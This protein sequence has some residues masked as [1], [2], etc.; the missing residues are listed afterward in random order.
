[1]SEEEPPF[2]RP[3][4]R[5]RTVSWRFSAVLVI[6]VLALLGTV[7]YE[8]LL[9]HH[10]LSGTAVDAY[11]L[12]PLAGVTVVASG[13]QVV[14]DSHGHFSIS[15]EHDS[16]QA[17][18]QGYE[19]IKATVTSSSGDVRL[20]L[21]PNVVHG[22]VVNG[23]DQNPVAGVQVTLSSGSTAIAHTTT[24]K[25]GT[26]TLTDV[27]EG[28]S[29]QFTAEDFADLSR[30]LDHDT[31]VDVALQPD[32]LRGTLTDDQGKPIAGAVVATG[33]LF[34]T[35]AD[36][37]TYRLKGVSTSGPVVFKASG[38]AATSKSLTPALKLDAS[39]VPIQVK[40]IYA[41]AN[42]ASNQLS[43]DALIKIADTTEVNAIVVDLKDS[44]GH[45]YYDSSVP[46]A[47]QI[48]AIEPE[49]DPALLVELL[50]QHN[51]YAIARIVVFEDPILAEARPDWAIHDSATGGLWRTWNGLA[52]VNAHRSEVW[53]YDVSIAKEAAA[54]GF[55]EIQL[56]YIRF[57]TDGPLNTAE[58]G[59]P[60]NEQTRP[61]AINDFLTQMYAAIAP[62]HAYL[63]A[64]VFGLTM[65]ETGDGNIG[66]NLESVAQ[67]LDY[68]CPMVYPSH[69]ADGSMG[70]DNPNDHP[71]E[72]VLW[73][74][75]NGSERV[76]QFK[77]K[78]RP[79]L[80]DFSLGE[81][82][83]YGP[84]EVKRQIDAVNDFGASGWMFW[85]ADNTYHSSG[86][87]S[88]GTN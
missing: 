44:T 75:E 56:D 26:Y 20:T 63:A 29:V 1:M 36:D 11:T 23:V 40:A 86:F 27:P 48:G 50:H 72:V 2:R 18:K 87:A 54:F 43:L 39:L 7:G 57:P 51:I 88:N 47:N 35:T 68:V 42:T 78:L 85:N 10:S 60:Q 9:N 45:I 24:G 15:G 34:T 25:D 19:S 8:T 4:R 49:L 71:Y 30:K 5:R 61:E 74:L 3:S 12:T 21:R 64:D 77:A 80:Q 69:F 84:T 22:T 13:T 14:T 16:V 33:S 66:Q 70:F 31:T 58:Y 73:S 53:D 46:L 65:W 81:G 32:V 76:P 82:I 17:V 41:T 67:H 62:T 6:A 52:W 83:A 37:G 55:D 38:F 28:A 59:V 79:W